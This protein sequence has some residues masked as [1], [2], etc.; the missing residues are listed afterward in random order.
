MIWIIPLLKCCN[1]TVH[2]CFKT[3][4]SKIVYQNWQEKLLTQHE[5]LVSCF[6]PSWNAAWVNG[7]RAGTATFFSWRSTTL[8][9]WDQTLHFDCSVFTRKQAPPCLSC[10]V[11]LTLDFFINAVTTVQVTRQVNGEQALIAK[12]SSWQRK[13]NCHSSFSFSVTRFRRTNR[14][15]QTLASKGNN[16]L[17]VK[18]PPNHLWESRTLNRKQQG[19][20]S[21]RHII[22]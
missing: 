1:R 3:Y 17:C 7:G 18:K 22:M 2:N 8:Y 5:G 19:N 21:I 20:C 9:H 11:T 13:D 15:R 10:Y 12:V 14:N 16:F 4:K 6:W